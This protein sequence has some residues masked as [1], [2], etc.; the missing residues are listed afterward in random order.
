LGTGG[1]SLCQLERAV[2]QRAFEAVGL[3]LILF[4]IA[5]F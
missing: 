5:V 4:A 1:A 3:S 2:E